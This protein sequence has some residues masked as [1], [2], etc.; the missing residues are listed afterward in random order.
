MRDKRKG[1]KFL[2]AKAAL[3]QAAELGPSVMAMLDARVSLR[4]VLQAIGVPEGWE[5]APF[6]YAGR[7]AA[8]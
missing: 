4:D 7:K 1:Q 3:A 2:E 8:A 6:S 5:R